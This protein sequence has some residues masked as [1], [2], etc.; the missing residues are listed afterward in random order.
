MQTS[1]TKMT[2]PLT[3]AVSASVGESEPIQ[4]STFDIPT[5]ILE[6]G[7]PI[8]LSITDEDGQE[9]DDDTHYWLPSKLYEVLKWIAIV[10]LPACSWLYQSLGEVWNLPNTEPVAYTLAAAGTFIAILI[11]ASAL[12][13]YVKS[14]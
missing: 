10:V 14:A 5:E 2:E 12:K 6:V 8:S 1:T 4:I 7:G 9:I 3:Y 11:G 13:N